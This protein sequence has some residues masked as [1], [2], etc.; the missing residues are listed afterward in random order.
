[1]TEPPAGFTLD[2]LLGNR[3]RLWQPVSGYRAA[4]DPVFL[5]AAVAAKPGARVLDL[6][7]GTGAAALCLAARRADLDITG[8]EINPL[9]AERARAAAELNGFADR[10]AVVTA[11]L[12]DPGAFPAGG[13]D[14]AMANPPFRETGTRSADPGR[15]AA[16]HEETGTLAEWIAALTRALVPGGE[17]VLVHLAERL[18]EILALL[19]PAFGAAAA[20]PL[21]PGNGRPARRVLVRAIRGRRT[22][23][24]LHPGLVLH[25][26]GG[27]FTAPARAVLEGGLSLDDATAW[28]QPG[29]KL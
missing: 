25:E 8:L 7:C 28:T 9:Y 1:M 3:V 10:L 5:A 6:G 14:A 4:I 2:G 20:I 11:D 23:F 17:M 19:S 12:R 22:P 27:A 15:A 18:G 24:A 16:N 26:A 21:W 29:K 13:F